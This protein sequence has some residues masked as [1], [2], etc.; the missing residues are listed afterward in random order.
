MLKEERLDFIIKKLKNDQRVL[1]NE[2]SDE[3]GISEDTVRRDIEFLAKNRMLTKVRGGAIPH[4]PNTHNFKDRI[5]VDGNEKEIIAKKALTLIQPGQTI[6][7]DGGTTTYTLASLLPASIPLT[8]ITNNVPAAALLADH[9]TIDVI[10]LGGRILRE[11]QVSAGAEAMRMLQ[12]LH[13]DICF[14]GVCS[15]HDEIG[16]TSIDYFETETKRAMALTADRII[17][18]TKHDKIGTAEPYKVCDISMVNTIITEIDPNDYLFDPYK[19]LD[20]QII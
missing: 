7:L 8:V 13:V 6:L 16:V 1:L 9:S 5:T 19:K 11:S 15:L 18:V 14:I 4:S 12:N 20:I 10:M 2:L 3:L 17:A